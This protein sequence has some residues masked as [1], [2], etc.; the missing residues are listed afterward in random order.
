MLAK[1]GPPCIEPGLCER[2]VH[3]TI[4]SYYHARRIVNT[5]VGCDGLYGHWKFLFWHRFLRLFDGFA[6]VITLVL[7]NPVKNRFASPA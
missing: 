6:G 3:V 5:H 2:V 7:F 4:L 1:L